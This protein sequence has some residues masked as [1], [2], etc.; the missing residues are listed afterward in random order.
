MRHVAPLL[1][2]HAIATTAAALLALAGMLGVVDA[3]SELE[4]SEPGADAVIAS[5]PR[6]VEAWFASAA[7]DN[8]RNLIAVTGPSGD[9][10]DEGET[11]VDAGDPRHLTTEL[12]G[13]LDAGRYDVSWRVS[14]E[15]G[16]PVEGAF[17]FTVDPEAAGDGGG[18]PTALVAT[19]GAAAV[20]LAGLAFRFRPTFRGAPK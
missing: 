2:S 9:R 19:G 12:R 6:H 10:V 17:A 3:H 7:R 13:G 20:L 8:G 16:H 1:H 14:S 4:R 18:A 15:D 11:L 5:P